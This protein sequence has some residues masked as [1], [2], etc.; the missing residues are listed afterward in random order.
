MKY[1]IYLPFLFFSVSSFG[2]EINIKTKT[3][4]GYIFENAPF[5]N[6]PIPVIEAN[7]T[8]RGIDSKTKTD[9]NGKFEIIAKEGDELIISGSGIKR[10]TILVTAK[11]CYIINLNKAVVDYPFMYPGKALRKYKKHLRRIER[12]VL[13]NE[14]KGIYKCLD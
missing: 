6:T 4:R 5:I 13:S 9:S 7:I 2:Q 10:H 12:E 11:N 8:I 1:I 14:K 3:I